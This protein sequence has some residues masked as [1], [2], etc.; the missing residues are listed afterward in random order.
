MHEAARSRRYAVC[1]AASVIKFGA[2]H[3]ALCLGAVDNLLP[4]F[5]QIY[6]LESGSRYLAAVRRA[7]F[8]PPAFHW[9]DEKERFLTIEYNTRREIECAPPRMYIYE[10]APS[11]HTQQLSLFECLV[12]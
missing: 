10:K 6:T 9:R 5:V 4:L 11:S 8:Q 1:S 2:R 12:Y 7:P 3:L